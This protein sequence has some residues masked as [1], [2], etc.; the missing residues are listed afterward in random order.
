MKNVK[1]KK[2]KI[3]RKIFFRIFVRIKYLYRAKLSRAS[4]GLGDKCLDFDRTRVQFSDPLRTLLSTRFSKD[5]S[6]M[7]WE[8]ID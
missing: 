8:K 3:E 5:I 2:Q 7:N 4:G 6:L 1:K